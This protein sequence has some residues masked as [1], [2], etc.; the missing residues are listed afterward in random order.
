MVKTVTIQRFI[1]E[2]YKVGS[3]CTLGFRLKK[4]GLGY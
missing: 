1:K 4:T 3:W 2:Q